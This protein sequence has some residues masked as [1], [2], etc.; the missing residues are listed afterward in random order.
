M[1]GRCDE[2]DGTTLVREHQQR[3]KIKK[4]CSNSCPW[5]FIKIISFNNEPKDER[6]R[7]ETL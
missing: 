1:P 4:R 3:Y 7:A 5:K 2:K 6:I